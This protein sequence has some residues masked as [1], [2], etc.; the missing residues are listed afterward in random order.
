[1]GRP[2][3]GP[4][5]VAVASAVPPPPCPLRSEMTRCRPARPNCAHAWP[6]PACQE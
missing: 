5:L 6:Q 2:A 4:P 3:C 1:V